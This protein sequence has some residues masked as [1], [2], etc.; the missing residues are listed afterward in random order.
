MAIEFAHFRIDPRP[1]GS[2]QSGTVYRAVH[3]DTGEACALKVMPEEVCNDPVLARRF[4][5][6]VRVLER[7]RHPSIV[8]I[9]GSG[10][11]ERSPWIA[12]QLCES[13]S[14][15]E[16]HGDDATMGRKLRGLARVA[17][18]LDFA[19]AQGVVHRDLKPSNIL[20]DAN[21]NYLLSDF[22][23]AICHDD[24]TRITA[25][26]A[27]LG[28][29]AYMSPEQV[30]DQPLTAASDIYALGVIAYEAIFGAPP[31]S[32]HSVPAL[33]LKHVSEPVP[34]PPGTNPILA[35]ILRR[36]LSKDPRQRWATATDLIS[37]IN[38]ALIDALQSRVSAAEVTR[39]AM[40]PKHRAR[41]LVVES[42]PERRQAIETRVKYAGLIPVVARS[43]PDGLQKL[44]S[45]RYDVVIVR[46]E[47]DW[48]PGLDIAS[49]IRDLEA[50]YGDRTLIVATADAPDDALRRQALA[51]GADQLVKSPLSDDYIDSL[52]Q[53]FRPAR[54]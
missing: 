21:G 24:G 28:T 29:A 6:E 18:A 9:L 46:T 8:G 34:I 4:E 37:S 31:F 11:H 47:L 50:S 53:P 25:A 41:V 16:A 33:M 35:A 36:A 40:A 2:G 42:A 38:E 7:L 19:H 1:L 15:Q 51:H 54:I 12:M 39:I 17:S 22:G 27:V 44:Q 45:G 32:A 26:G 3:R 48:V 49:R 14:L 52:L 23:I 30:Q 5:R 13:R 43:G 20:V 10:I